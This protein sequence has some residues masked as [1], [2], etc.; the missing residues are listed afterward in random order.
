MILT[1]ENIR[2]TVELKIP[3]ELGYEKVAMAAAGSVAKK[4]GFTADRVDDLKTAVSE[5][6]INAIEHGHLKDVG[7]KET[8]TVGSE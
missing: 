4:M 7:T 6:C 8:K 1:N 3:S 2:H 5:A